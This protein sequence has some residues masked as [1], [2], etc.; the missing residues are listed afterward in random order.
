MKKKL[1]LNALTISSFVI[2]KQSLKGGAKP[3]PFT[4]P[5]TQC[6]AT[7]P[8]CDITYGCTNNT[9]DPALCEPI[10]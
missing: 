4:Q 3:Q 8:C 5:E 1:E 6:Y 10:A 2:N 7:G 9:C